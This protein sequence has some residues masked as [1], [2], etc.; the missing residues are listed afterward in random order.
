MIDKRCGVIDR[1]LLAMCWGKAQSEQTYHPVLLHMLDVGA[2]A[3]VL[4]DRLPGRTRARLLDTVS[5][6]QLAA[7]VACHDLGKIS[8]GFQDKVPRLSASLRR[9]LPFPGTADGDHSVVGR[10]CLP[11]MLEANVLDEESRF[12][13]AAAVASH[14]G[15]VPFERE[16]SAAQDGGG[17]WPALRHET[18]NTLFSVLK[19]EP[20]T[21]SVGDD[22][23]AM[24]LTGLTSVSDWIGSATEYFPYQPHK[25]PD[26]AYL[27]RSCEKAR[28]ALDDIG[29]VAPNA[30]TARAFSS[31]FPGFESPNEVQRV[32]RRLVAESVEPCLMIIEAPT[33]IGKTE[34]ALWAADELLSGHVGGGIYYALPTQATSNQMFGRLRRYVEA[35]HPAEQ[36]EFLLLHSNRAFHQ[37]FRSLRLGII[38][39]RSGTPQT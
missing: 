32:A 30:V 13:I 33:G 28:D 12:Q 21:Q 11:S 14:H 39:G 22:D 3:T 18:V 23:W 4:V 34:A 27:L 25:T 17:R 7:F 20:L 5:V 2:V 37:G 29:Y 35:R 6:E 38:Y 26:R 19:A 1:D 15:Q 36:L 24:L 31:V 10:V 9:F 16:F 8:P